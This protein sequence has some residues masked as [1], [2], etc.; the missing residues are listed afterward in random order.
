MTIITKSQDACRGKMSRKAMLALP[1]LAGI[2]L[3]GCATLPSSGP[4]AGQIVK[5][6][7]DRQ[8][9]F[10]FD[11]VPLDST[12]VDALNSAQKARS[13]ATMSLALLEAP[14]GMDILGP[15]DVLNISIYE[16]G[17]SLFART[18]PSRGDGFDPSAHSERFPQVVVNNEGMIALPYVGTLQVQG[19][20]PGQVEAQ[21]NRKLGGLSQR[22]QTIVTIAQNLSNTVIM[23]GNVRKPGR[24]DLTFNRERLLD[25]IALAGGAGASSE[26]TLV[27]FERD[28]RIIEQRLDAIPA[29]SRDDLVLRPKDHIELVQRPR[30]FTVFG[31]TGKVSQVSFDTG[32]VS[33]AEALARVQGPLDSMA[34]PTA[35]FV[36]RYDDSITPGSGAKPVIYRLNL[37]QPA[38]YFLAQRVSMQD[39]DVIYI[40]NASANQPS[41][42]VGIINQLFSPLITAQA[43]TKN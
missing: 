38:S 22:P 23:A 5:R 18:G 39:K 35:V 25:V 32:S 1:L 40:A 4:T 30:S 15:G 12:A 36:F 17:V 42:L 21:I 7:E 27:R 3:S 41:K 33:L 6:A 43:L 9:E 16:V 8:S 26:D 20:T 11:I 29:S 2:M 13:A 31:A 19:L 34:D 14:A 28:G 37:M 24:Y 10:Q